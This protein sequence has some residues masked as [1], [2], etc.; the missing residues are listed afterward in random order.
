[1]VDLFFGWFIVGL[2]IF[3]TLLFVF[4][5]D[6]MSNVII[7]GMFIVWHSYVGVLVVLSMEMLVWDQRLF[8]AWLS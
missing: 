4:M 7:T 5:L 8:A 6:I 3:L 2:I 1:M